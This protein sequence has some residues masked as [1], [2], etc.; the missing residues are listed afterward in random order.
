MSDHPA[1]WY[2]DPSGKH[3]YRYWDGS[4]WTANVS[5]HGRQSSD[6]LTTSAP[7]PTTS[8]SAEKIQKQVGQQAGVRAGRHPC[9]R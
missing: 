9:P 6:P 4:Q 2:P 3:E 8:Q 5:N 7:L 1:D